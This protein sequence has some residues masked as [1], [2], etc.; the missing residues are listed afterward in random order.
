MINWKAL[1][2]GILAILILGLVTQF[3]FLMTA[4]W[5]TILKNRQ[6]IGAQ[7]LQI[8]IYSAGFIFALI[9]LIPGGYITAHMSK[10]K[11]IAHCAIVGLLATIISL[12]TSPG[13]EHAT[14]KGAA[15]IILGTGMVMLGGVLWRSRRDQAR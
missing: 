4:T 12:A 13:S 1:V 14:V 15:F 7:E 6:E 9:T 8:M 3:A 5:F 11:V 2:A 10:T